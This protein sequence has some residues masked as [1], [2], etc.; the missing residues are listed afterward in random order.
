MFNLSKM[1]DM[2]TVFFIQ[3]QLIEHENAKFLA[4]R[5]VTQDNLGKRTAGVDGIYLLTSD[6]RMNL[7]K[8]KKIDQHSDKILR[9]IISKPNGFVR[10]RAKQCL[11]KCALEPQ[12]KAFFEPNSY[13]FRLGRSVN[14]SKKDALIIL[15]ILSYL[16]SWKLSFLLKEQI[17]AWLVAG[18]LS[19]FQGNTTEIIPE[20]GTPQGGIISPLL[21]NIALHGMEKLISK[22]GVYIVRYADD[23]LV[24]CNEENVLLKLDKKKKYFL[25]YMRLELPKE[26]TKITYTAY[27]FPEEN[28]G[29][30]FL[31][32][33][34]V[35]YKVG[36]HKSAKDSHG[37]LTGWMS[38]NQPS[39]KSIN[40]HLDNIKNITKMLSGLSQKVL[41]SKLTPVVIGGRLDILQ[42]ATRQKLSAFAACIHFYLLKKWSQK[43]NWSGIGGSKHW[44]QT[45]SANWVFGLIEE[46]KITKLN[47]HDQTNIIVSTKVY[48][49]SSPYDGRV[50]YWAKRLSS[51]NK[52]GQL[53]RTLL[54]IKGPKC[55]MCKIYFNDSDRIEIDH[56][57]PRKQGET[58]HW[59]NLRFLHDHCHDTHHSKKE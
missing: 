17:S 6:E 34:F 12:Y 18:I 22:R 25:V 38:R 1:G 58:S 11:V 36:I 57:T 59:A 30:D 15:T 7:V 31:G 54:K 49:D 3:K 43:K 20:S 45:N 51:N 14:D 40:K 2:K 4:V 24:L 19:N 50:I 28:S 42:Y 9:V 53:L 56:I 29:I 26:K 39:I 37:N 16:K 13:G 23:F 5:K 52:Y 33:N 32:F 48:Q 46:D 47:R 35:N 44:I 27:L 55:N 41:I 21:V 10:D 8:N